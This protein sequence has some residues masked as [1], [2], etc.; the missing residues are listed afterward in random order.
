M[1]SVVG[2]IGKNYSRAFILDGLRRLEYRGYDSSGFA[3]LDPRDGRLLYLKSAGKLPD[4]IKKFAT[5]PIDGFVGVGHTRWAT[6]G[7]ACEQNAHPQFDCDKKLAIVHNG[8]VENHKELKQE[9]LAAD[10]VFLSET[11]TEVIA[12]IFEELIISHQHISDPHELLHNV[13]VDLCK[14]IDGAFAFICIMEQYPDAMVLVRKRSPLCIGVGHNEMFA[15]SDLMAFAHKTKRVVFMPDESFAIV[16]DSSVNIY[17]FSG[18]A[19]PVIAQEIADDYEIQDKEGHE[20]FMLKEIY[21]HKDAISQSL[22]FLRTMSPN[23]WDY[24]GLSVEQAK[25]L[26]SITLIGCGTSWHAARIAQFY[27][28]QVCKIPASVILASEFNPECFFPAKNSLYLAVSQS[29]ETVDTL[30]VIRSMNA[31]QL[32]TAAVTNVASSSLVREAGGFLLTQAGQE[33]AVAST[34]AF[35]TQL[36]A[37]FWLAHRLALEKGII[38]QRQ[39][40]VAESDLLVAAEVLENCIENYK[41][42]I[43]QRVA[44]VY[45]GYNKALF[46]GRGISYPFAM[47]AALKLKEISYVFAQCCP[48]GEFK[49]G[50]LALIDQQ[51]PVFIFS[52]QDL[53]LYKKLVANAQE[54]KTRHG[55]VVA[56]AF[57]GQTELIELADHTFII[58]RVNPLLGPLA[59]TGLMQFFFYHIAKQLGRPID[60]PRHRAKLLTVE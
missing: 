17:D 29:G 36:T 49:H 39:M 19:V 31:R 18:K 42:D 22:D 10:H 15:A 28:A 7:Q 32:P 35:S 24:L 12:H 52:H 23:V 20:H 37:L 56:F 51:T 11:D 4:L 33:I 40:A 47:E 25:A 1:C 2:Y 26:E 59:M 43:V 30:E 55:H 27:F 44:Q 13:V 3:C 14:R 48:A 38:T 16:H 58:P 8:I 21:E 60:S 34:K 9:L 45:A 50:T 54:I 46:L 53:Y 5:S 41:F 57:D 6:H